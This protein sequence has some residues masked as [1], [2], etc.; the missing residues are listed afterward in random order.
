MQSTDLSW[1]TIIPLLTDCFLYAVLRFSTSFHFW[2]V[3]LLRIYCLLRRLKASIKPYNSLNAASRISAAS[4]QSVD[5]GRDAGGRVSERSGTEASAAVPNAAEFVAHSYSALAIIKFVANAAIM[6]TLAFEVILHFILFLST[7][8][9][10][11][12][13]FLV[14]LAEIFTLVCPNW[15]CSFFVF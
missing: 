8:A 5:S 6:A 3:F 4:P 2:L 11:L 9:L 12:V 13:R 15:T 14:P 7:G 10:V 1:R